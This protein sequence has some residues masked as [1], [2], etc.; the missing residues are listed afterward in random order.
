MTKGKPIQDPVVA[1]GVWL[2]GAQLCFVFSYD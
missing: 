2:F 1:F